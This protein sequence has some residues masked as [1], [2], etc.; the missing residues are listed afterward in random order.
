MMII[1]SIISM[2][3]LGVFA[4]IITP[5]IPYAYSRY[6]AV[7]IMAAFDSIVGAITGMLQDKFDFKIF[8]SGFFVNSLIAIAFTM[9]GESLDVDIFLA[10]IVVFVSR[11]FT[12]LSYIR[13]MIIKI[14]E[15][16]K[17]YKKEK[18]MS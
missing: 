17:E 2:C 4:G 9:F 18:K 10:A 8:V 12:N 14:L 16:K 3:I 15:T 1:L 6:M 5:T 7:A 13:R 11:I